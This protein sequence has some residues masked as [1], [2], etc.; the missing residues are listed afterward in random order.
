MIKSCNHINKQ[1]KQFAT[2]HKQ[3]QLICPPSNCGLRNLKSCGPTQKAQLTQNDASKA[4]RSRL[5][6]L[7]TVDVVANRRAGASGPPH[8]TIRRQPDGRR[9]RRRW[10]L[11]AGLLMVAAVINSQIFLLL[12]RTCRLTT[13][14]FCVCSVLSLHMIMTRRLSNSS[15]GHNK[16]QQHLHLSSLVDGRALVCRRRCLSST[17]ITTMQHVRARV[18]PSSCTMIMFQ[19]VATAAVRR[20]ARARQMSAMLVEMQRRRRRRVARAHLLLFII[21]TGWSLH[22]HSSTRRRE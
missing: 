3:P 8:Y 9:R 13:S 6:L 2:N 15:N 4:A 19:T 18:R 10:P 7:L 20:R 21:A 11:D 16:V 1:S 17:T 12:R 22:A 14:F 5:L